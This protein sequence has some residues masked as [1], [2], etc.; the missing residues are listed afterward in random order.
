MIKKFT[1]F[2]AA[3][4][5]DFLEVKGH[6]RIEEDYTLEDAQI[7]LYY[8]AAH[9]FVEDYTSMAIGASKTFE[10]YLLADI[11]ETDIYLSM[12]PVSS[13]DEVIEI[14]QKTGEQTTLTDYVTVHDSLGVKIR[15]KYGRSYKV[16]YTAGTAV[17]DLPI[18]MKQ[19]IFLVT[20]EYFENR[21]ERVKQKRTSVEY[22]LNQVAIKKL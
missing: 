4:M 14:N 20:G 3:N 19:A 2:V 12:N 15:T 1:P 6:L 8:K 7:D 13:I 11:A 10:E 21:E 5:F 22:L 16:T 18:Q 17:E 9:S